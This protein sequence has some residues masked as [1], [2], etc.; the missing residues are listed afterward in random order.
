MEADDQ[1]YTYQHTEKRHDTRRQQRIEQC[2]SGRVVLEERGQLGNV[3]LDGIKREKT[4][5]ERK[6]DDPENCCS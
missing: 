2:L 5:Q 6:W 3:L 1:E 4:D